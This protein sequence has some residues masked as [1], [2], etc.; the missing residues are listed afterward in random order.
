MKPNY[1]NYLLMTTDE[2]VLSGI[3][4]SETATSVTLR[5]PGGEEDTILRKNIKALQSTA[6]SLMPEGLEAGIDAQQM[7]DLLR[8]L[9]TLK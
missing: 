3:I 1:I 6:L 2:Q 9:Q 4:V 8:F 7:A 5:R